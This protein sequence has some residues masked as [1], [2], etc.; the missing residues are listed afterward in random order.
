MSVDEPRYDV[1]YAPAY[2]LA[3]LST[4]REGREDRELRGFITSL[5][6]HIQKFGLRYPIGV[7]IRSDRTEVRPGKC[8]VTAARTLGYTTIPAIVID[9]TRS[10]ARSPDWVRLPYDAQAIQE[11]YFA[12]SDSQ[13]ECSRRFFSIKKRDIVRRPGVVDAFTHELSL[14]GV[15]G[16]TSGS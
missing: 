9:F 11:S 2:A 12:G 8:R 4:G 10:G 5:T 16:G 1:Y 3:D 6:A 14:A 13:V 7:H 15:S